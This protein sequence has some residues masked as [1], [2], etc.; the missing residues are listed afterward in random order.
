MRKFF[1][2]AVMGVMY[3]PKTWSLYKTGVWMMK[4]MMMF[5]GVLIVY[6]GVLLGMLFSGM[7]LPEQF[8]TPSLFASITVLV[9]A[10]TFYRSLSFKPDQKVWQTYLTRK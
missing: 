10:I 3:S 9:V 5:A 7:H 1:S 8:Y 4:S 2:K 6:A